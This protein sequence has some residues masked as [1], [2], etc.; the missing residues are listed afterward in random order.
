MDDV[1]WVCSIRL[2]GGF[3]NVGVLP[4]VDNSDREYHF[5]VDGQNYGGPVYESFEAA[6]KAFD[7][8]DNLFGAEAIDLFQ[9]QYEGKKAKAKRETSQKKPNTGYHMSD[10]ERIEI[11]FSFTLTFKKKAQDENPR[12]LRSGTVLHEDAADINPEI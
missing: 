3:A 8:A 9:I 1:V 11:F 10:E 4:G 7:N 12:D 2:Q 6:K 5:K